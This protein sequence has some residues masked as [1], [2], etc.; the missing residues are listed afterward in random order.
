MQ[1]ENTKQTILGAGGAI[2][3]ELAKALR[4]HTTDIRLVS[5]NPQKVNPSDHLHHADLTKR[6]EVFRAIEGSHITYVTIGFPYSTKVWKQYW[7]PFMENVI[8]AC[9]ENASKLVFFDNVYAM[10]R[11]QVNHLTE[12]SPMA[13]TSKKGQIR[14][15]VDRMIL[16]GMEK[17]ALQAIIARSPDFYGGTSREQ[18]IMIKLV[19]DRLIKGKKAQWLCDAKKVHSIGYVPDLALGTAILGNTPDAYNRIWNLPTDPQRITGE[20]WVDLFATALE[21]DNKY[22]VLPNWLVKSVG[23]FVP[24]MR[25]IAEMNYQYDRDYYFDSSKFNDRFDFSPTPN[26]EGVKRAIDQLRK[27]EQLKE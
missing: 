22:S 14:A 4:D 10:G 17:D 9:L 8:S 24:I 11:D 19:Y 2:G 20:G 15:A 16:E 7:P 12:G 27:M 6:H 23:L 25:E 21:T 13:P 3:I 1:Q 18:S 26:A 5:R